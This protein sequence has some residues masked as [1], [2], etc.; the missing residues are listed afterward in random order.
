MGASEEPR[1]TIVMTARERHSLTEASLDGI[2]R[3]TTTPYRLMYVDCAA[4]AWLRSELEARATEWRLEIVRFEEPLWPQQARHRVVNRIMTDYVVFIDNDVLVEPGWLEALVA[5]ADETGAGIV[6]PLYLW[7]DGVRPAKIHMAG[8]RI[9][10]TEVPGGKVLH[11]WHQ[12]ANADP[13]RV[14]LERRPCDFAEYHCMLVRTELLRD[15]AVL[16]PAIRCVH[17]HVDT[18]LSVKARGYP[19][20]LE[21]AS[22]VTYLAFAEYM[23]NELAFLR[24]RW[25]P[26]QGEASIAAF[27]RKWGVIDDER[28]FGGVRQFLNEHVAMVD[29]VRPAALDR[30]HTPMQ[31]DD[32]QQTRSGLMDLAIQCGYGDRDLELLS[33][34]HNLAVV[35]VDGGYRG[36]GRPFIDHLVGTASVLVRY[37]FRIDVVAAGLLHAAYT[38][39]PSHAGDARTAA[40]RVCDWLG[41]KGSV[42][43]ARV[44]AYTHRESATSDES[45]IDVSTASLMDAEIVAMVAAHE[46]DLHLSGELRYTGRQDVLSAARLAEIDEVCTLL[47]VG[48]LYETL[49]QARSDFRPAMEALLTRTHASYRIGADRRSAV[50]MNN[51]VLKAMKR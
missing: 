26:A 8:G 20:Y 32:H 24:E 33:T 25:S 14:K 19:V 47:G 38:H 31:R 37:G 11:E 22:R 40:Q 13:S 36:C 29:P 4:P 16:D 42:I 1:V 45:S 43:E 34:C 41:G 27:C 2:A 49:R 44:R 5:C 17:E 3:E 28:S 35:L 30:G 46:V 50:P 48:G 51:D 21:P 10:Q 39:A 6:A 15:G 9:A 7:G 18:A 12:F 23:L